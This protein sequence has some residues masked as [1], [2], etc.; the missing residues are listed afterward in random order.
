MKKIWRD[1]CFSSEDIKRL[2]SFAEVIDKGYEEL[3][4]EKMRDLIKDADGILTCW[5]TPRLTEKILTVADKLKIWCHCA[6]TVKP[7]INKEAMDIIWNKNI[8]VT[9]TAAALGRGVAEFTLGM[10]IAGLKKVFFMQEGI[11]KGEWSE[12]RGMAVDPYNVTIGV[13][14][15]GYCGS[16]LIKLLQNFEVKILLYDPYKDEEECRKLGAEK[17]ELGYLLSHSDIITLH[18]PN[19]PENVNLIDEKRIK[20][21]KDEAIFINTARGI[22]V[23]EKALIEELKTGRFYACLDVTHPEPPAPDNPLRKMKNVFLTPHIAGHA[24][25]GMKRQGKYAVDEL[26]RFFKG[27]EVKYRVKKEKFDVIA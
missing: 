10:I 21:I 4:E 6:G 12:L 9:N 22:E 25:N 16:H 1:R 15:A 8:V 26:E 7:H 24:S 13:I 2:G 27:E 11:S 3:D 18:A 20:Q 23:D 14:G 5:E 17:V 19:I